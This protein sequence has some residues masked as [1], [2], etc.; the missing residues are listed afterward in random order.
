MLDSSVWKEV[1]DRLRIRL[2]TAH[3]GHP[4]VCDAKYS[5]ATTFEETE[6][7]AMEMRRVNRSN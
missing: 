5:S 4:T 6:G 1:V 2:H 7:R 3:I